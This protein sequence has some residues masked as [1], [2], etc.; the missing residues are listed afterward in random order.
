MALLSALSPKKTS[1]LFTFTGVG[2][3]QQ[4]IDMLGVK[5]IPY[6]CRG[7]IKSLPISEHYKHLGT[8]VS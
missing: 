8:W 1:V 5:S 4:F 7:I 6:R 2:S 3:K